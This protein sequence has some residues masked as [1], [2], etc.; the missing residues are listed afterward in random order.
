MQPT[1]NHLVFSIEEMTAQ[2]L[3]GEMKLSYSALCAFKESPAKFIEYKMKQKVTTD[4]MI[5]GSMVHC[6]ILEPQDF[7]NRYFTF[8]DSA[9]VAEIG[10]GN[11]RN[12][13]AY[14]EWKA[15]AIADAG[16]RIVVDPGDFESAQIIARNITNNR[17]AAKVLRLCPRH[18]KP[19]EWDYKNFKFHGF[20]DGDGDEATFDLKI[21]ADASPKKFL[22]T[23]YDMDYHMQG[24]MYQCG[25]ERVKRHYM[26][27]AD[28]SGGVSVHLLV[29]KLIEKG[30]EEYDR[31]VGKFNECILS[32][33]WDHNYDFWSDRYDGIFQAEPAN[34]MF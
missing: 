14:K 7:Y 18:E 16:E 13:K 26:I 25:N 27:A 34:W 30:M 28:R 10:G 9:K 17:A 20:I 31:L 22:R 6:L 4:A 8:D 19:I 29:D 24:A 11:P 21:C 1:I 5:F 2:L 15:S 12:T 33:A 3:R 23:I 32:D